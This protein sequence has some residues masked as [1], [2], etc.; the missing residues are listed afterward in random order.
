MT[1]AF[2]AP[3]SSFNSLNRGFALNSSTMKKK[4]KKIAQETIFTQKLIVHF[5]NDYK[6]MAIAH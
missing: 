3:V 5:R 1:L 4:K 6:E 2:C